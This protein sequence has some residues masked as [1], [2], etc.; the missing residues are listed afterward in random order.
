MQTPCPTFGEGFQ[1]HSG[2]TT[3]VN[4]AAGAWNARDGC[5]VVQKH[6]A[7][8]PELP[9]ERIEDVLVN[10][11]RL[12]EHA[13]GAIDFTDLFEPLLVGRRLRSSAPGANHEPSSVTKGHTI[14]RH[15]EQSPV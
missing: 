1:S 6:V 5:Q 11:S 15:T 14:R 12:M 10:A 9:G 3:H 13:I 4:D 8:P 2:P 7:P